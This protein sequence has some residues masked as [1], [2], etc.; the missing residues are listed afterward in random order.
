MLCRPHTE[1]VSVF[2]LSDASAQHAAVG[3]ALRLTDPAVPGSEPVHWAQPGGGRPLLRLPSGRQHAGGAVRLRGPTGRRAKRPPAARGA[4]A[5]VANG[6]AATATRCH[7]HPYRAERRTRRRGDGGGRRVGGGRPAR[8]AW[9]TAASRVGPER[10]RRRRRSASAAAARAPL[11]DGERGGRRRVR[12]GAA[13][14]AAALAAS[15]AGRG[16]VV[17]GRSVSV[18]W[19]AWP[20]LWL[21]ASGTG[22]RAGLWYHASAYTG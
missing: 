11:Q 12:P 16:T 7:T 22:R 14:R 13:H 9:P 6:A 19:V 10:R 21:W 20:G 18:S 5:T 3:T 8:V 1:T 4:G 15:V 17:S 2:G